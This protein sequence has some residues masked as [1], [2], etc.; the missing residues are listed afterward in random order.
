MVTQ[1]PG[2]LKPLYVIGSGGQAR[3]TVQLIKDINHSR[4]EWKIVGYVDER[5]EQHGKIING[6]PVIGDIHTLREHMPP[7]GWIV[8]GI[9]YPKARFNATRQV[10]KAIPQV[11]F[12]TLIH[13]TAV[14]GENLKL[15][16]GTLIGAHTVITTNVDMGSHVLLNYNVTISHDVVIG[17]YASIL[18]GSN[19]SGET[20]IGEGTLIGAGT[21]I[22]QQKS[23]GCWAIVG[24]GS[25]VVKSL[26][27]YCKAYGV[28]A[29]VVELE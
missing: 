29:Q 25:V 3:E 5:L 19:I 8:C 4:P 21:V 10:I 9:G 15:G 26:P 24:A 17:S 14:I 27:D 23:V 16:E 7:D 28:P 18:P 11:R 20:V 6:Y 12:A 1:E 22:T 2:L 13:P